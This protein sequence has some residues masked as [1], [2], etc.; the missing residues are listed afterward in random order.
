MIILRG[1]FALVPVNQNLYLCTTTG[2]AGDDK[3]FTPVLCPWTSTLEFCSS[4]K[5]CCWRD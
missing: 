3:F 4:L 2:V 5:Q 1:L